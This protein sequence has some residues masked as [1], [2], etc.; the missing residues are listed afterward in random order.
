MSSIGFTKLVMRIFM[1]ISILFVLLSAV[2]VV[3]RPAEMAG[4]VKIGSLE[5]CLYFDSI[6]KRHVFL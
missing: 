2:K 4:V 1:R 5:T 6:T 3:A